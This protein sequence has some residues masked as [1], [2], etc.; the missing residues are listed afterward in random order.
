MNIV[1]ALTIAVIF[2]LLLIAA[3]V[4]LAVGASDGS[5]TS[6]GAVNMLAAA[7]NTVN[8]RAAKAGAAHSAPLLSAPLPLQYMEHEGAFMV[9]LPVGQNDVYFAVDSG[10]SYMTCKAGGCMYRR[11]GYKRASLIAS[12]GVRLVK[13]RDG[14]WCKVRPCPCGVGSNGK[15]MSGERCHALVYKPGP[16]SQVLLE[17]GMKRTLSY[18]SQSNSVT[19]VL[20]P[21]TVSGRALDAIVV[22]QI[23]EIEG[24]TSSNILGMARRLVAAGDGRAHT[25]LESARASA[26]TIECTLPQGRL[27]LCRHVPSNADAK[28]VALMSDAD[29]RA[30]RGL[31]RAGVHFYVS[32]C[33]RMGYA[34]D[35][36]AP[37]W[38]PRGAPAYILFDTGTTDS[39]ADLSVGAAMQ[40]AGY[41]EMR[42]TLLL[43]CDPGVVLQWSPRDHTAPRASATS[44]HMTPGRTL[45]AFHE[46]FGGSSVLMLGLRMMMHRGWCH[47]LAAGELVTWRV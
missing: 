18:G 45:P 2:M 5:E 21:L 33:R 40:K 35:S 4:L 1:W 47:D 17:G 41:D 36:G 8:M 34:G 24:D 46:V 6:G 39:F 32:R 42:H 16:Q 7:C 26:W 20:E 44:L 11:C 43:E 3:V 12:P 38:L 28:T 14:S 19:H 27:W 9:R 29:I 13:G 22:Y 37:V 10:S 15:V 25:L 30:V 23:H 31:S